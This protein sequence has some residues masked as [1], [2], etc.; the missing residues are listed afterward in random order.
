MYINYPFSSIIRVFLSSKFVN[1]LRDLSTDSL[2]AYIYKN[3]ETDSSTPFFTY[4][5]VTE[6]LFIKFLWIW[7]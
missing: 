7:H 2:V 5:K 3:S 6:C 4:V 1:L